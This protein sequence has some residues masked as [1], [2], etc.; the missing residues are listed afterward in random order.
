MIHRCKLCGEKIEPE[1]GSFCSNACRHLWQLQCLPRLRRESVYDPDS[2][3]RA[4]VK[5]GAGCYM[6]ANLQNEE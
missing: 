1:K 5:L 4:V 3:T 6:R 2:Q